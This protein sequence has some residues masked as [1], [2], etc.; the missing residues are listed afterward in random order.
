M[1]LNKIFIA[2]LA[3]IGIALGNVWT[4][5]SI[6]PAAIVNIIVY[7]LIISSKEEISKFN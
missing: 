4:C 5:L 7:A 2:I 3:V 1:L 6:V